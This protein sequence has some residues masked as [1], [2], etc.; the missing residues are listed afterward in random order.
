MF[1]EKLA[2]VSSGNNTRNFGNWLRVA[3]HLHHIKAWCV[4]GKAESV[5]D[6]LHLWKEH[7]GAIVSSE[8][9]K[10]LERDR[11]VFVRSYLKLLRGNPND[12]G[13]VWRLHHQ[14]C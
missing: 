1:C 12:H 7:F 13:G 6:T 5:E 11:K 10:D 8:G 3:F 14:R 2:E 9:D 4:I